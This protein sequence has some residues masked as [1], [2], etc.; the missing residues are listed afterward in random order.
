LFA[1]FAR[2][3][4]RSS[5]PRLL[6]DRTTMDS[7]RQL[8]AFRLL[9]LLRGTR[10]PSTEGIHRGRLCVR[11]G[12]CCAHAEWQVNLPE[13]SKTCSRALHFGRAKAILR[14]YTYLSSGSSK[15]PGVPIVIWKVLNSRLGIGTIAYARFLSTFPTTMIPRTTCRRVAT[16]VLM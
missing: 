3:R 9:G 11:A 10:Q 5:G 4:T 8:R 12:G 15:E 2:A 1:R 6:P 14:S 7:H 16:W 13:R